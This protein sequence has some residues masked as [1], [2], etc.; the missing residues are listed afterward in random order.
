MTWDDIRSTNA[1]RLAQNLFDSGR[2]GDAALVREM[3]RTAAQYKRM[4]LNLQDEVTNMTQH[5]AATLHPVSSSPTS[6]AETLM[7]VPNQARVLTPSGEYFGTIIRA[8][9]GADEITI[10]HGS[11]TSVAVSLYSLESTPVD[12]EFKLA[13]DIEVE[14]VEHATPE[15][16]GWQ[17]TQA[18]ER[19]TPLDEQ[20]GGDH[21][22]TLAIQ[23]VEYIHANGLGYFEG[24]VIKYVTRYKA[25]NGREDLEKAR[26]YIDLMI[27]MEYGPSAGPDNQPA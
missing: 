2:T 5:A 12:Y 8:D 6:T 20:V 25:K 18:E 19:S 7:C 23:P 15:L 9:Y 3:A 17:P 4:F 11:G 21:Y 26:H 13:Y 16:E 14:G 22:K 24:N 27:E 10:R 1:A